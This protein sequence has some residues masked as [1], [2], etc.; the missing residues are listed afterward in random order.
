MRKFHERALL[1]KE[2]KK[3]DEYG[4]FEPI[5]RKW[6]RLRGSVTKKTTQVLELEQLQYVESI[7]FDTYYL[8]EVDAT[9][10]KFAL[11]W[12]ERVY[13]I[14]G[15][16]AKWESSVKPRYMTLKLVADKKNYTI[17]DRSDQG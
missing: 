5:L 6:Y 4:G 14:E 7:S 1:L 17:H 8:S 13:S 9:N 3:K 10:D 15:I 2:E 16:E 11:L 12:N